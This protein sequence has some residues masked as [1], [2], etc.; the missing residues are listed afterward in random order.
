MSGP[1]VAAAIDAPAAP[2]VA[3]EPVVPQAE[4]RPPQV[5]RQVQVQRVILKE[6][7]WEFQIEAERSLKRLV[8]NKW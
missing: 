7:H 3:E 2:V 1:P 5:L 4:R 8:G 6:P